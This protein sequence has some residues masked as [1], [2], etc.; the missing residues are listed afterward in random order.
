[1]WWLGLR[2]AN[3][4]VAGLPFRSTRFRIGLRLEFQFCHL[5]PV[6]KTKGTGLRSYFQYWL[7]GWP[8]TSYL[9]SLTLGYE[10][11]TVKKIEK[12]LNTPRS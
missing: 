6:V 8:W 12:Q 4:T 5:P 1:M 11:A 10:I 9:T 3:R 2:G 7:A